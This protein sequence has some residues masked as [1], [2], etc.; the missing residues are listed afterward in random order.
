MKLRSMRSV[1]IL[2]VLTRTDDVWRIRELENV[3]LTNPRKGQAIV[4]G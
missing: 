3:I 1:T 4:R 2:A